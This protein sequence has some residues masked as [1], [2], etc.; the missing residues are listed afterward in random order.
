[1]LIAPTRLALVLVMFAS[2]ALAHP[3]PE[4]EDFVGARSGQA[5]GGLNQR[6]FANVKGSYWWSA[7]EG[8]CVHMPVS[9]GRFKSVDIVKPSD[10]GMRM[11]PKTGAGAGCPVDVTEADRYK[12]P[13]CN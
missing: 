11:R 6:G 10:C 9:Q 8:I 7:G 1:M 2:P 5:E 13:D 4:L 12:Y 3:P